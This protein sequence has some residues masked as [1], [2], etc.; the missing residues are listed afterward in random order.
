M[1][2]SYTSFPPSASK[3]CNGSAFT[4]VC[5]YAYVNL[6]EDAVDMSPWTVKLTVKFPCFRTERRA[7]GT[8]HLSPLRIV[9]H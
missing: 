1:S 8:L 3:A 5:T 4:E 9:V 6:N 2:R 7:S